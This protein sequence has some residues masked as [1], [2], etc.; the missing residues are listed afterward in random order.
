MEGIITVTLQKK[1]VI[2]DFEIPSKCL[3]VLLDKLYF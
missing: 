2:T 1:K 3:N